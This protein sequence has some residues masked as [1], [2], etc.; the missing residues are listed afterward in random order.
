[1]YVLKTTCFSLRDQVSRYERLK[2]EIEELQDAQMNIDND[3]VA[4]L[5][6][7][8]LEMALHLK[9]KFYPHL[10]T[11]ISSRR[12]S[13]N[14]KVTELQSLVSTKDLELKDFNITVSSLKSKNDNLVDQVYVLKTTC[15]S[16]RDQV[17]RY[18]RLKKEI[19]ELQDAQMNI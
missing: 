14:G 5:D 12:N 6:A 13:L 4:K 1:V 16:L 18:E 3:K 17:S 9:E 19:E 10:L 11:T 2:K 8:L 7:D 15:F